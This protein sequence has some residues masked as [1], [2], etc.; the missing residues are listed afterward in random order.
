MF[1]RIYVQLHRQQ[2]SKII[3]DTIKPF[4]HPVPAMHISY[5]HM[6]PRPF[7]HHTPLRV[8]VCSA[9]CMAHTM[10][11]SQMTADIGTVFTK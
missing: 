5:S 2:Q 11:S 4:C 10:H 9:I 6:H 8:S 1:I 3:Q 7:A